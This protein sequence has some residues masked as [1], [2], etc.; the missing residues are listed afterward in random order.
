MHKEVFAE[1]GRATPAIVGAVYSKL[2]LNEWAAAV[3]ILY[4]IL[5]AI[6]LLRKHQWEIQD[7]RKAQ[8]D[9]KK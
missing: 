1:A 7:R 4:V 2:T 3:T 8:H 6:I 9:L 5:Q